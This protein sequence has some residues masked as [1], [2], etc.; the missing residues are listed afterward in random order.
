MKKNPFANSRDTIRKLEFNILENIVRRRLDVAEL[1]SYCAA[2]KLFMSAKNRKA[3]L[4]F[5]KANKNRTVEQWRRL[6]WSDES[7]FN[8]KSSDSKRSVRRQVAK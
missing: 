3:R 5:A 4:E 1:Y 8:L 7:K 2:K 6:L